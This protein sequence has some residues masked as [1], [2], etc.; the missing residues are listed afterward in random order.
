MASPRTLA[1]VF[2]ALIVTG[3]DYV[4]TT[5]PPPTPTDFQGTATEF[6]KRGLH[7][8]HPISG[9]PGCVDKVLAPTAITFLAS[10]LDQST[11]VTLHLYTFADRAT[12][13]RLRAS[14]DTCAR[15]FVTDPQTYQSIEQSPFVI[16]GQG[17]WSPGFEAALRA[18]MLV[19][20]GSGD[21]AG[22]DYP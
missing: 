13:E 17:P 5:P 3:C 12:F 18:G 16:A 11:P 8:D 20:A 19:A 6:A 10:G 14:I 1:L 22:S 4:E 15:S 9:D 7:I 21:N 2:V